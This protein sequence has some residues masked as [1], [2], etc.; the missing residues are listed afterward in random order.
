MRRVWILVLVLAGCASGA[1]RSVLKPPAVGATWIGVASDG[2]TWYR[3]ALDEEGTGLA[4]TTAGRDTAFYRVRRWADAGEVTV[5]LE[6]AEG[7]P[8]APPRL[9]LRGSSK[10]WRLD[11]VVEGRHSVT[12]W[13]EDDLLKARERMAG[14]GS[15]TTA[16]P[17]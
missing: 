8:D 15:T 7:A 9:D 17:P 13:R 11:L 16:K 5:H 4:A 12:L 14:H 6:L 1:A 3:L 2:R 10:G